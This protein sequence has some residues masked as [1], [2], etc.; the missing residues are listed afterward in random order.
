MR[1]DAV[2]QGRD[3]ASARRFEENLRAMLTLAAAAETRNRPL[4]GALR[5]AQV[6][7]EGLTVRVTL[8]VPPEQLERL[9]PGKQP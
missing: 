2:A 3:E 6:R 4:A 8:A 9:L 7:R 1:F 5:S